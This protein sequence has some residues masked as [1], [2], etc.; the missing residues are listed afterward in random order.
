MKKIKEL[1]K[2]FNILPNIW[3]A[4]KDFFKED[5]LDKASVL[6]Y[7]SIFSTLFILTFF[8]FI[9]ARFIGN[10]EIAYKTIYPFSPD[11]FSKISPE[12]LK[13]AEQISLRLED[14][15]IVGLILSI[16][17]GILIFNKIIQYVNDM[18][19][20]KLKKGFLWRRIKEFALLFIV[21]FL[22]MAS[23]AFTGIISTTTTL[24]YK[25]EFIRS[26]VNSNFIKSLNNVLIKYM[27]P[28]LITFLL[29]FIIYKWIPE[30]KVCIRASLIAALFS[31]IL[32]EIIKR[33]YAYYLVNL[34]LIGKIKGPIIAIILFGFWMEFSMGILLHGAKLTYILNKE[35]NDK[36]KTS[37]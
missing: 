35:K 19:Y 36:T 31:T 8:T 20:V 7:Y 37:K 24:F 29:F 1:F 28:F 13:K 5:G 12:F 23:F 17:L 22:V 18:F 15:G 32:W 21:G 11:F 30:T 9:F 4:T 10:P 26:H 33:S 27:V 2:E 16:V 25:N 34:S 6:A 14:F 3:K